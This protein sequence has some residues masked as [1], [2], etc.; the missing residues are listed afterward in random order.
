M[1]RK[2]FQIISILL[3]LVGGFLLQGC[4]NNNYTT[5]ELSVNPPV[6]LDVQAEGTGH[7]IS[8][9]AYNPDLIFLGYRLFVGTSEKDVRNQ[10]SSAGIDCSPLYVSTT[11]PGTYELEV[12]P[13]SYT[14]T[15]GR[16]CAVTL[17]LP[18]GSW[19]ALRAVQYNDFLTTETGNSSNALPVP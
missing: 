1:K 17:S 3:L 8:F 12:K 16:V 14:P 9:S 7:V 19:V 18:S 13:D 10:N 6:L 11:T 4:Q 2:S 15:S 5:Q